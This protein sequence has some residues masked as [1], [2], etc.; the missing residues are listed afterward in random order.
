M[1]AKSWEPTEQMRTIA[2]DGILLNASLFGVDVEAN[3]V[4]KLIDNTAEVIASLEAEVRM[5]R[6]A[7]NK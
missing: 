4:A 3:G 5:L 6:N 1:P 7:L 2:K